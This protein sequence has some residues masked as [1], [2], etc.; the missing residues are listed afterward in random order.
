MNLRNQQPV[1]QGSEMDNKDHSYSSGR[2]NSRSSSKMPSCMKHMNDIDSFRNKEKK[3]KISG[4]VKFSST[5]HICLI[6]SRDELKHLDLYWKPS[7]YSGFKYDAV[8]ELRA[9][10]ISQGITAKEAIFQMYQPH[11]HERI[12]WMKQ[13]EEAERDKEMDDTDEE[14]NSSSP[15]SRTSS[16]SSSESHD[17]DSCDSDNVYNSDEDDKIQDNARH[18]K[19]LSSMKTE[20]SD[21]IDISSDEEDSVL[22]PNFIKADS[23]DLIKC[24]SRKTD[25]V[26][27]NSKRSNS[28]RTHGWALPWSSRKGVKSQ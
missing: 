25:V 28:N 20:T 13:Y 24:T 10:L 1:K 6:L 18:D 7:E 4:P 14:S 23:L 22:R 11:E 21:N 26:Q 5:V 12:E 19:K 27:H 2:R 17:N 3:S 8:Q 9:H 16:P 15:P